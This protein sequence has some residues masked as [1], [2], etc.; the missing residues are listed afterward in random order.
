MQGEDNNSKRRKKLSVNDIM[1][2]KRKEKI[3]ALTA[4]DYSTA[5]ICDKASI[6]IVLRWG[7]RRNDNA[8]LSKYNPSEHGRNAII[9]QRCISRDKES[10]DHS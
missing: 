1:A 10:N 6:D 9:L 2:M 4:Y 5:S 7:Q 8:W 3:S